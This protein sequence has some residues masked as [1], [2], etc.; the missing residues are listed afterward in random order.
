MPKYVPSIEDMYVTHSCFICGTMVE[1]ESSETCGNNMCEE[2]MKF[3]KEDF[4]ADLL[5][6][7]DK[8]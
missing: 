3:F 2:Q 1:N 6:L 4:E 5:D 7:F 8:D